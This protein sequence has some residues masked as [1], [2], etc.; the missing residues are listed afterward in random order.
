[1]KDCF[2]NEFFKKDGDLILSK[3]IMTV[4]LSKNIKTIEQ[5]KEVTL[6]KIPSLINNPN[7][8]I[9]ENHIL[10]YKNIGRKAYNEVLEF[11]EELDD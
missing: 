1:M 3:R 7:F 4:L 10:R 9:P 2:D 6:P 5:L 11:L 8:K